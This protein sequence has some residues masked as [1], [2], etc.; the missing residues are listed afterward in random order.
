MKATIKEHKQ[1][2][3]YI[4]AITKKIID[5]NADVLN[6]LELDMIIHGQCLHKV[7]G[8][9]IVRIQPQDFHGT[10]TLENKE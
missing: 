8:G 10:V 6:Q 1:A 7:V 2:Q 3:Q 5:E 4:D 9:K